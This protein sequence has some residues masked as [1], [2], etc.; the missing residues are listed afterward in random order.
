MKK[1]YRN[2]RILNVAILLCFLLPFFYAGCDPTKEEKEAAGQK[3]IADSIDAALNAAIDSALFADQ[4]TDSS[5]ALVKATEADT[6]IIN[7][8]G[9]EV[10]ELPTDKAKETETISESIVDKFPFLKPILVPDVDTFSGIA[11]VI[12]SVPYLAFFT[13]FISMLLLLISLLSKFID[14]QS[15]KIILMLDLLAFVSLTVS[16][17]ISLGFERRYGFIVTLSLLLMQVIYDIYLVR[18]KGRASETE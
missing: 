8:I 1:H 5:N 11:I 18:I 3:R 13:A 12:D 16:S 4:I 10:K 15:L 2:S 7:E 9:E 6:S 17:P 14:K